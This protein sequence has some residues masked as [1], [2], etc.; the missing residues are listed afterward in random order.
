MER[1]SQTSVRH[2][3][4]AAVKRLT[5]ALI[6][7]VLLTKHNEDLSG[8]DPDV[9]RCQTCYIA[10]FYSVE[11]KSDNRGINRNEEFMML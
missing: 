9:M 5:A 1:F 2:Q 3:V 10:C 4:P 8:L 11:M 7:T 6:L